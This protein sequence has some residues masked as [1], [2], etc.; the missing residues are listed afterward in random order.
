MPFCAVCQSY[1]TGC[2]DQVIGREVECERFARYSAMTMENPPCE[3]T[4]LGETKGTVTPR[5]SHRVNPNI[6]PG[7]TTTATYSKT[8]GENAT[9]NANCNGNCTT[10][11]TP[12]NLSSMNTESIV[13]HVHETPDERKDSLTLGTPSKGGEVHVYFDLRKPEEARRLIDAGMVLRSY[14]A[15][16]M[17]AENEGVKK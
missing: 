3:Q 13:R 12:S 5:S 10:P 17:N 9:A 15:S 14:A 7:N 8:E 6:E 1:D 11:H 2:P 16:K 4:T